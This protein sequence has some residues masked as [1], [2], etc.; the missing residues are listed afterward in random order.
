MPFSAGNSTWRHDFEW[1][2]LATSRD[3]SCWL[4]LHGRHPLSTRSRCAPIR[5]QLRLLRLLAPASLTAG[6][7][8]AASAR[9]QIILQDGSAR[10]SLLSPTALSTIKCVL[11]CPHLR[12]R[13]SRLAMRMCL[14]GLLRPTAQPIALGRLSSLRPTNRLHTADVET[15]L[16]TATAR[17]F[18]ISADVG[19]MRVEAA[20]SSMLSPLLSPLP[21]PPRAVRAQQVAHC[22][23]RDGPAGRPRR[24]RLSCPRSSAP[25][26]SRSLAR[27]SSAPCPWSSCAC[28]V[29]AQARSALRLLL[30]TYGACVC[31]PVV[32]VQPVRCWLRRL[33]RQ[34]AVDRQR[35]FANRSR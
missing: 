17:H 4:R 15:D 21:L 1:L 2:R 29:K 10:N 30:L 9:S 24:R 8:A 25:T 7:S 14:R 12:C 11:A 26:C 33:L 22:R 13:A 34:S 16:P 19:N 27:F 32:A 28:P 6:A 35:A 23:R 5:S 31:C 20:L 3:E 18:A